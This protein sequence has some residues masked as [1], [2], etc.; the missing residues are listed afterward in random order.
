MGETH[1][2]DGCVRRNS[3]GQVVKPAPAIRHLFLNRCRQEDICPAALWRTFLQSF[4]P[5]RVERP[6]SNRVHIFRSTRLSAN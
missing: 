4:H 5:S 3:F 6:D 2:P 1:T